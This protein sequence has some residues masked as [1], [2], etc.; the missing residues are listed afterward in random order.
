MV[1]TSLLSSLGYLLLALVVPVSALA[2][3]LRFEAELIVLFAA[4]NLAGHAIELLWRRAVKYGEGHR[5]RRPRALAN[6]LIAAVFLAL[7]AAGAAASMSGDGRT[8]LKAAT[9]VF[10]GGA[11]LFAMAG[12]LHSAWTHLRGAF[13]L[14][15][16]GN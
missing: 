1:V 9:L 15:Q 12:W 2:P 8:A 13:E 5:K 3:W 7:A 6:L 16:G 4:V 10:L 14:S 11:T